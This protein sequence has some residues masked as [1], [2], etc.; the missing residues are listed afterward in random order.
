MFGRN[1]YLDERLAGVEVTF[2]ETLEG[3]EARVG[4]QCVGLLRNYRD[5]CQLVGSYVWD[6]LLPP[7]LYFEKEDPANCP[8]IAVAQ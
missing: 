5:M 2:F 1:A 8:R 7:T 6:K 3:L 4:D